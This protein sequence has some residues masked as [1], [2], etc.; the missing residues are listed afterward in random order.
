[1]TEV[2]ERGLG[3]DRGR[4]GGGGG[5]ECVCVCVG[6]MAGVGVDRGRCGGSEGVG[7]GWPRWPSWGPNK[8]T[9][10]VDAKQHST[11]AK[12]RAKEGES[13]RCRPTPLPLGHI[14]SRSKQSPASA[15]VPRARP[16]ARSRS[17]D[18]ASSCSL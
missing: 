18:L 8:P 16:G 10:S 2:G 6:G 4:W 1:M 5:S 14:G 15:A 11:E 13:N 17:S 3:D 7:N 12:K 9:A